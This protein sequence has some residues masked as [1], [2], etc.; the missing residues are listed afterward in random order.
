MSKV[1][2]QFQSL[3]RNDA[4]L[5]PEQREQMERF[6]EQSLREAAS[7]SEPIREE[8]FDPA[9][10]RDTVDT[11]RRSG[12]IADNDADHLIR[13]LNDALAP[14]ERRE[15]KLAIEFSRR[16]ATDGEEKAVEWLRQ[17]TEAD[18]AQKAQDPAPVP[19]GD[20]APLRSEVVNSRSRR[21]RGPP[22]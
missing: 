9:T 15:S 16:M 13:S 19:Q 6:L 5:S 7:S 12:N 3:L 2:Q 17:Q 10:W 4:N 21:L 1:Q 8:I 18:A 14:L 22:G 20:Y 11:L